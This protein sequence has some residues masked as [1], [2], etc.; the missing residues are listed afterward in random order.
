ME[1]LL[2][3]WSTTERAQ[4]RLNRAAGIFIALIFVSIALTLVVLSVQLVSIWVTDWRGAHGHYPTG[5]LTY[6]VPQKWKVTT[7]T[8]LNASKSDVWWSA[9]DDT[10]TLVSPSET[11]CFSDT[12]CAEHPPTG[13]RVDL[14]SANSR[15]FPT[16]E[17]WYRAWA[18]ATTQRLGSHVILPLAEYTRV[19][20]AGQTALCA[21]SQAGGQMLP[22]H[23]APSPDFDATFAGYTPP[24]VGQ[25]VVMC[26]MMW[27]GRI[28]YLEATVYLKT[29]SQDADIQGVTQLIGS[30][31]FI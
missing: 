5:H 19:A 26:F 13:A 31:H 22:P 8:G 10:V 23:P 11:E 15:G 24:Y 25:A 7:L 2:R 9:F 14:M 12:T 17:A 6:T 28:Y 3:R 30:L 4:K 27:Q 1:R 29:T 16:T 18:A 20:L 21:T